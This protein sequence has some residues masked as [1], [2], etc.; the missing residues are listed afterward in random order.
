MLPR[1]HY[2]LCYLLCYLLRACLV[3]TVYGATQITDGEHE[4]LQNRIY[5]KVRNQTMSFQITS[6]QI[7]SNLCSVPI[8]GV[9]YG[10]VCGPKGAVCGPARLLVVFDCSTWVFVGLGLV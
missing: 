6:N 7:R 10:V 9:V 2:P 4:R 3:L 8:P 5:N 1:T